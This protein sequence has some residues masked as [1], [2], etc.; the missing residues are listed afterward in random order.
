MIHRNFTHQYCQKI[1]VSG[2]LLLMLV[3][4]SVNLGYTQSANFVNG[5]SGTF[6]SSNGKF[7]DQGGAASNY[8]STG[9]AY[10][11]YTLY[12][13][14][15]GSKIRIS[16]KYGLGTGSCAPGDGYSTVLQ[17]FNGVGT[18]GTVLSCM[19][20]SNGTL[21]QITST[22]ATGALTFRLYTSSTPSGGYG[23]DA[24]VSVVNPSA[25]SNVNF[26]SGG[27]TTF[28]GGTFYDQGGA[29]SNYSSTGGA[30]Q[31]HTLYPSDPGSK[32]R[33]NRMSWGLGT[34]GC[35]PGDGYSTVLEVFNGV[36]AGGS[37][38]LC[39]TG[40]GTLTS[41]PLTSTDATGALTFR[42]YTSGTP[43]GAFG[44][45][46]S[47]SMLDPIATPTTITVSGTQP[48]CQLTSASSTDYNSTTTL[49]TLL[50]S[51]TGIS[52]TTGSLSASAINS[53]N[54]VVSWP[55]GWSGSATI[56]V[57][58][59]GCSR[60]STAATR[61]VTVNANP[62]ALVLTGSTICASPGSNGTITSSTSVSGVSYQLYNSS[63]A[64][65]QSAKSGTGSGLSW[66]G[67]SAG[68]GYYVRATNASSCTATS[69]A[70]NVATTA[71]PTALVLTG[72]TICASPGS[73]GTITSSTSVSGVSYQLYNSSNATVQSAKSGTGSG[74]SWTGLSAGNGYYVIATNAATC[75]A[76]S[77]AVNVSTTANPTA[78]VLT[79]S[80]ICASP[81]GN[82]T[83]TS[84]T[85]V[86]G[87][88]YQLYNSSNATV[89]SAKSG[90]G[91]GLSWTGLSA[92]NGY[93]VIATNAATCTATSSA[94]NVSTT[95]NPTALVLTGSTI[96][97]SPGSNG[98]ITSSTSVSGVSYQLYNSSNATVQ[99][100][101]SG[102]GS[103]LSWTGLSAGN[104]YYVIAT[105]AATCTATSSAVNV[106]TTA[107][108]TALVLTGSTICASPGSN[109]TIT[110]ST[111]VSGVSYQLYNSSN[112]TVQSAKS[113]TG[114]GLSWTGLSAG[115]GYY[116]RATNA[117]SCTAT[118]SAVN[119][120]TTANPT[121]L[122]LT[123]S[124]ICASPGSN[125]TITSSTSVSGVSYQLYNSSNATV[126]SAKSGTGSGLSWTGLS[127]GNG[128]YVRATNASSCTA[129]SSAV[130]VATTANPT[131]LVLT[132]STICASPGSNGTIT[133]STSVSGVSYQLYNSSNATVQSA[134]SGTGSGLSWTGLS[135]GNGYYVR[136]TNASSCTATSS[137]VNVS[138]TA[139]PTALVLTG[140]TICASPGSNGT[141]T[142]S[143]S[144]SG[145]SYQLYNSSNATVQSAKSG[146]GSGLSW[147]GLS[148]GNGY[149][150]IATN[151]ATCTATSSA[152]NVSTTANPTALVLT[153]STICASPGSNGTITSSTSVSGVSYQLYNSSNATVQSAKS[154]TGSGLSWTGLSA[155][156]GYY[157]I[158]TNAA[159]CTATSSAVN[160]GTNPNP[161]ASAG[162]ALSAIC[163][164]GTTVALGGSVGGGATG[165]TW[166]DGGAGGTF[167]PD[168]TTLNATYTAANAP[169]TV[170]LTLTTSGGSCGTADASK[171]I[172]VHALPSA[173]TIV[174]SI[175]S[176]S[177][178]CLNQTISA[179]FSGGSGGTGTVTD[180]YEYSID[181][182]NTW[183]PYTSAQL[184][185]TPDEGTDI[186][187]I[188][189]SR[190][191]TGAGC[192]TS[193]YNT[194][195]WSVANQPSL[196]VL[197]S[198]V[199]SNP[200][201]GICQGDVVS[202]T[203]TPG[204]G[205]DP[206]SYDEYEYSIDG[207]SNWATYTSAS[208]I[209]TTSATGSV[210]VRVRR[211][212]SGSGCSSTSHSTIANWPVAVP[213]V[214]GSVTG[215]NATMCA[216][217]STGTMTLGGHTGSVVQW[218]YQIDGGGWNDIA[219]A[220]VT[221]SE[222]PNT[223]G[224]YEYRA[225]VK[226]GACNAA[227][228]AATTLVVSAKVGASL[229]SNASRCSGEA[230]APPYTPSGGTGTHTYL[231]EAEIPYTSG[232]WVP[233]AD[234]LG[235]T[236]QIFNNNP[237]ADL[238]YGY[239][240]THSASGSGCGSATSLARV[241]TVLAPPTLLPALD[242]C[243]SK[244]NGSEWDYVYLT[245]SSIHGVDAV[246]DVTTGDESNKVF[247]TTGETFKIYRIPMNTSN[248]VFEVEDG[249]SRHCI[250]TSTGFSTSTALPTTLPRT[251]GTG[252]DSS[253]CY[254]REL[255]DWA[256]FKPAGNSGE[257]IASINDNGL[258]LGRVTVHSYKE[259]ASVEITP[260][261]KYCPVDKQAAMRR[262][263][264]ISSSEYP[265]GADF[266]GNA[267]ALVRLYFTQSDFDD[268][269]AASKANNYG[270]CTGND[271]IDTLQN[272]YVTKY[273][274]ANEDGDF[275]NN[276][277]Q[278][279][280]F[281]VF[282]KDNSTLT[283]SENGF[284]TVFNML[285]PTSN[286]FVE[287][288]VTQFSE[289]WLHGGSGGDPL[290]VEMLYIEAKNIS[291]EYISVRWAT[292]S[293][294]N[295][296]KFEVERSEDGISF[297]KI[298]EVQGNGTTT[299]RKD[300]SYN[301]KT[302]QQ[303]IRYYYRLKQIDFDET[304]EY[305]PIVS[306]MLKGED[307]FTVSE[308]VPN[309]AT[310]QG[311]LFIKTGKEQEIAIEM[312]NYIGQ[313]VKEGVTY[314]NKGSNTINVDF[315]DL[316]AG[317]YT[318]RIVAG[319]KVIVRRVVIAR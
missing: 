209:T 253:K 190:T 249:S 162:A 79:G 33:V 250:V 244:F 145:V 35:A 34:G 282:Y 140:S 208:N 32:L 269:S 276:D 98:T 271:D 313:V 200:N 240:F 228:S 286:H 155:G 307:L 241:L 174:P 263:F 206:A 150:V 122:V 259:A 89:Q 291:N 196:P 177:T 222:S 8:G 231:L 290:P 239:R 280:V 315:N 111:S 121:A 84:S 45:D 311:K 304:Y 112:A 72:S 103:G 225:E 300:Y 264:T 235:Y 211:M 166:D 147:T 104:G 257:V 265:N 64:T 273:T 287:M 141:I 120:A 25:E 90:T 128:Y 203:I 234:T 299:E 219:H 97:A 312:H 165:G 285:T 127:A 65:V 75:T 50:W 213:T 22:D 256:H 275:G 217:S 53:S 24:T 261:I 13:G 172:A 260:A 238:Q 229:L 167:N 277:Y 188:R 88:S 130:N 85:S 297:S 41:S 62:T 199:P 23:W 132:G 66:T 86:S 91:S 137:A 107:N 157:V 294:I 76:T 106:S 224:T 161:T 236:A 184:I 178:V 26:T 317:T 197:A 38:L 5:G 255:N 149:Y 96:C 298:G 247:P 48:S 59:T 114:S 171:T 110:S 47:I 243:A 60:T 69:S 274:G 210:Q 63:N 218:Q 281:R 115:N 164:G 9:G 252:V 6:C 163:A 193:G 194:G 28:S 19:V 232:N 159:T 77:S 202:A 270:M 40:N 181:Y 237:S 131:A 57:V 242:Q 158:A 246:R 46:A 295:N 183:N 151:A 67:L 220:G 100:A 191:A 207:G 135:A 108:P 68:N 146:T 212:S 318:T 254:L 195:M 31:L 227:Y 258:D 180:V 302:A 124:T 152:V 319:N 30:L 214:G 109:G 308:F 117:S 39:A 94:V 83:I 283:V 81:G 189:V 95:A 215:G 170:T 136:A 221:Y 288:S 266:A 142:S 187:R 99:S 36:G 182:G 262:H 248:Q 284:D 296:H 169:S 139:N 93:Y 289:F 101:K 14:I 78:L 123:G 179:T 303:G 268:L 3:L 168:A 216:E 267:N 301:D 226:S 279:G 186:I 55:S 102:T 153:G 173:Q 1:F 233:V 12:P 105:N 20:G 306:E 154:G 82:G 148:A 160:I 309:P 87:V 272:L 143:T 2:L 293:E 175:S 118:S 49:G 205:G 119:V 251:S 15:T 74:L 27:S 185:A 138:T 58:S 54:G 129:T 21:S 92:G 192:T 134:K 305:S 42:L 43:R 278:N 37:R 204:S 198:S 18:G 44:W 16:M 292:A 314:L 230:Y 310:D 51:L 71:N 133:S 144:V 11:T 176:G 10:Q 116:V 70:V 17:V 4:G 61:N 245:A 73:N 223:D 7:Y 201:A 52:N 126:Q 56:N 316:A 29:G 113:G 125:G 80:T 156:N